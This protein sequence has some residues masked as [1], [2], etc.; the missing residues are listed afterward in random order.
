MIRSNV[1]YE[2]AIGVIFLAC[3]CAIYLL[4][5]SK[6]LNIYQWCL[7]LGLSNI[8][9][10]LRYAVQDWNISAWIKYSLPDGLYCA[11][12]ILIIDAIWHD[13]NRLIK[14]IIISLVPVITICSELLQL[15]GL[16]K[17]WF[18]VYDLICYLIP[19][20]IYCIYNSLKFNNFKIQ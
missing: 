6:T 20:T 10:S 12:Y 2:T 8:I 15:C 5:R 17:G 13:D 11:A 9:D 3:G 4:F 18:D 19:P 7:S 1:I 14:Y 16:V